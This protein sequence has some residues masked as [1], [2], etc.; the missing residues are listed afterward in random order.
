MPLSAHFDGVN[1]PAELSG[2]TTSFVGSGATRLKLHK[3][4]NNGTLTITKKGTIEDIIVVGGGGGGG[5]SPTIVSNPAGL[6]AGGGGAGEVARARSVPTWSLTGGDDNITSITVTVGN[7]GASGVNNPPA[8]NGFSSSLGT[9]TAI[10]GGGGN[11]MSGGS[12]GGGSNWGVASGG[13]STKGTSAGQIQRLG[14]TG[15]SGGTTGGGGGGANGGGSSGTGNGGAGFLWIDGN[16]YA[17]GGGGGDNESATSQGAGGSGGSGVGGYGRGWI[18][19]PGG[20]STQSITGATSTG[21]GG[22]GGGGGG[23]GVVII[24]VADPEVVVPTYA[25]AGSPSSVVMGSS[26]TV[27]ATTTDV[28]D[29]TTLY[30]TI[31]NITT[32][33][34]DFTAVNGTITITNNTGTATVTT[35]SGGVSGSET[36]TVSLRTGS[37]SGTV[38]ATTST[39]TINQSAA[40]YPAW[41]TMPTYT[42]WQTELAKVSS[43][44]A[45]TFQYEFNGTQGSNFNSNGQYAGTLDNGDAF[46]YPK[47]NATIYVYDTSAG[48]FSGQSIGG[49]SNTDVAHMG[50]GFSKHDSCIYQYP[51][52]NSKKLLKIDPNNSYAGTVTTYNNLHQNGGYYG[53]YALADG[54]ILGKPRGT[55]DNTSVYDPNTNTLTDTAIANSPSFLHPCMVQ[56][57]KDD[58]V[59]MPPYRTASIKKWDPS[60]DTYSQITPAAGS[61]SIPSGDAYQDCCIGLDE[62]IYC[63]PWSSGDIG[64]FDITTLLWTRYDP[65]NNINARYGR[66]CLGKDGVIYFLPNSDNT[67]LSIDTDPNSSTYQDV[68]ITSVSSFFTGDCWGGSV[69]GDG[70]II[71]ASTTTG[72]LTIDTTESQATSNAFWA[73]AYMNND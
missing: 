39:L 1:V 15:A 7:G 60:T 38:E 54:R 36:F 14:N 3:F 50:G 58:M 65:N 17:G 57:P 48:T 69:A 2:G 27:T 67:V 66:G 8:E 16:Y 22:G 11:G 21:S 41:P 51:N 53:G 37:I 18:L 20:S 12:G 4:T 29:S 59:Y 6:R 19:T 42:E 33:N 26:F 71:T 46:V 24:A 9:I 34:A 49:V 44:G 70:K 5:D 61:S 35:V 28:P 63:S 40:G 31:N 72:I 47:E 52:S 30:Y 56:H 55:G 45:A 73:S 62:K 10:G 43:G 68:T 64:I 32:T 23:K 25:I 13:S